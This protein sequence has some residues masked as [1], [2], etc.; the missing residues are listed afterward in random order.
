MDANVFAASTVVKNDM[1]KL[2][3][4]KQNEIFSIANMSDSK[5]YE[6]PHWDKE[7]CEACHLG[8]PLKKST[9]SGAEDTHELCL[10]CHSNSTDHA[11]IHP[12]QVEIPKSYQTIMKNNWTYSKVINDQKTLTCDICHD[13][14]NQC[15]VERSYM[16][17]INP[18]FL[19]EGP[20]ANS[21]DICFKCHNFS[22]YEKLNAHDQINDNDTLKIN[23]CRLCHRVP[24]N[25]TIKRGI[26]KDIKYYPIINNLDV[27]RT[28]LCIRCHKKIDH[29]T[30][31][32]KV[33]SNKTFRHFIE[34]TQEKYLTLKEIT[35]VTGITIPLEPTSGRI[36]CGTCHDA[37]ESGVF[38]D[39]N[40]D[41][42]KPAPHRLRAN[43]ICSYCHDK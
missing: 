36:Y 1:N 34:I 33:A 11:Y 26:A 30:S 43:K 13:V 6:N 38:A 21:N 18:L 24:L 37:H 27:D 42:A 25:S 3:S 2:N 41:S 7:K 22:S 23:K 20:Y 19:R 14:L 8:D 29:P 17:N 31:A 39:S 28:L 12:V 15:L 5:N 9:T 4:E 10:N 32:M 40:A 16:K 35:K